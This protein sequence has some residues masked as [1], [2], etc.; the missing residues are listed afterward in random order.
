VHLFA[1][2]VSLRF[3]LSQKLR[4]PLVHSYAEGGHV[5]RRI[6]EVLPAAHLAPAKARLV[7]IRRQNNDRVW[8]IS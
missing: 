2:H 1:V 5:C 7:P 6:D 8:A 3:R 4:L